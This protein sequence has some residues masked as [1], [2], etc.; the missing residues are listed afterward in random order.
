MTGITSSIWL[1]V[2]RTDPG[3]YLL[4]ARAAFVSSPSPMLRRRPAVRPGQKGVALS[5]VAIEVVRRVDALFE[6]E[7]TING[8]SAE[9]RL[10]VRRTL[11]RPLTEDLH[12]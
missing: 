6:I 12:A 10:V 8:Q 11:S 2:V 5:P 9:E 7:R 4:G 3:G 1:R